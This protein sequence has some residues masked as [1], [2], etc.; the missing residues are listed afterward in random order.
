[1]SGDL[2]NMMSALQAAVWSFLR[3]SYVG[4]EAMT[5]RAA[6]L[7]RF[8]LMTGKDLDDRTFRQVVSELVTL[9]KKPICT[10]SAGGFYVARTTKDLDLAI[11][12]LEAK[13]ATIFERARALKE[14]IP[15]EQQ[16]RLF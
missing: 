10:T 9:Y 4:P 6:I 7:V 5:P 2:D 8:N 13:G 14:T 3:E 1:M 16:E 15:L 11:R 12:D